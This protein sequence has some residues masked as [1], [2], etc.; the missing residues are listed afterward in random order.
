MIWIARWFT[1]KTSPKLAWQSE[2]LTEVWNC[3]CVRCFLVQWQVLAFW[4]RPS[5]KC[6]TTSCSL[7]A[8]ANCSLSSILV[9]GRRPMQRTSCRLVESCSETKRQVKVHQSPILCKLH[10]WS[11]KVFHSAKKW[12][13]PRP[14]RSAFFAVWLGRAKHLNF[15]VGIRTQA[16]IGEATVNIDPEQFWRRQFW[17]L[18]VLYG[19]M[20]SWDALLLVLLITKAIPKQRSKDQEPL[21]GAVACTGLPHLG[22]NSDAVH[23]ATCAPDFWPT[24]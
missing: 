3:R 23:Q 11:G 8:V 5:M 19:V 10:F 20:M 16:M 15:Q 12:Q 13:R 21:A 1:F 14:V 6:G 2:H 22:G 24:L 17:W 4:P 9:W 7:A 18:H